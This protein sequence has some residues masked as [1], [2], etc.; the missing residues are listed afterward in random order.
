MKDDN[1]AKYKSLKQEFR[2][3]QQM[4]INIGL[5]KWSNVSNKKRSKFQLEEV[6]DIFAQNE[7]DKDYQEAVEQSGI[8]YQGEE[9]ELS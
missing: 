5:D 7:Q 4:L 8:Q 6:D 2:D 1:L 9:D 3:V